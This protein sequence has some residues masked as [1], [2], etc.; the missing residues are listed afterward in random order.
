LMEAD[1]SKLQIRSSYNLAGISFTPKQLA[2]EIKKH[3]PD[4]MID[5]AP[6]FRQQLADSWPNSIDDSAAK[7]DWNWE[8]EYPLDRL[9]STM[10]TEIRKKI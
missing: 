10:L 4:F 8:I 3:L 7:R 5:Y 2:E 9:V 6:D 1:G